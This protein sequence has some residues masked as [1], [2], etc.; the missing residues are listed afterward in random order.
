MRARGSA[1]PAR[2]RAISRGAVAVVMALSLSVVGG[3][4]TSPVAAAGTEL[5]RFTGHDRNGYDD[6]VFVAPPGGNDSV[7]FGSSS[8]FV[9][10]ARSY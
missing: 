3:A 2:R 5:P 7:W 1:R 9:K 4:V 8:G 10:V 6:I